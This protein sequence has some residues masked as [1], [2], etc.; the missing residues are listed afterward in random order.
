MFNYL[1]NRIKVQTYSYRVN[2]I[3]PQTVDQVQDLLRLVYC[4]VVFD[5]NIRDPVSLNESLGSGGSIFDYAPNG[6]STQDNAALTGELLQ[7]T[8]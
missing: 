7:S 6:R 5:T 4:D 8:K 3:S 2:G 1:C